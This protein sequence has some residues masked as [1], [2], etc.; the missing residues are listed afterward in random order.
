MAPISRRDVLY[1]LSSA[2]TSPVL[3]S[4]ADAEVTP[5]IVKF[6]PEIEPLVAL[7]ERTPRDRCAEMAVE[8]LR[9]G[10]SYRQLLA[11]LFLGGLALAAFAFWIW[12]LIHA[13]TNKGLG[14]GEKIAWVLVIF[15][16]H[17]I[18][19]LIYF[20]IGRPK[21]AAIAT[22]NSLLAITPCERSAVLCPRQAGPQPNSRPRWKPGIPSALNEP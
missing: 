7:I 18:G 9:G 8:Q 12:M 3:L 2:L 20:F 21:G 19:A 4:R 13:V 15:F 1:G 10:V 17:F 22:P 16:L 6:R 14:D 11:A 5:D